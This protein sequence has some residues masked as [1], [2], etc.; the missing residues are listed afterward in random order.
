MIGSHFMIAARLFRRWLLAR[1]LALC[2]SLCLPFIATGAD[3]PQFRGANHDGTSTD[4]L[5]KQ[6]TG[7]VTNPVW[8]IALTN[9]LGSLA[10]S[11]GR[12][13]TQ[14]V[15]MTNGLE[16]EWCV[17]LNATNGLHA[18]NGR[19]AVTRNENAG[20]GES[21]TIRHPSKCRN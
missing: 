18:T 2:L 1:E 19:I 11:D 9:C 8:R 21:R 5:N 7:S 3:W 14:T 17:A 10:V 20:E 4:R 16:M 12:V 13:F 6:W 15:R